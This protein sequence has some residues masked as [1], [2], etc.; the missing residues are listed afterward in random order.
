ME[1]TIEDCTKI[2][3]AKKKCMERETSGTDTDCNLHNCDDCSLCYEQGPMGEQKGALKFAVDTMHKYRKI[4]EIYNKWNDVN[5]F[6][7]KNAMEKIGEVLNEN[8]N[9]LY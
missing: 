2:L 4:Q 6:S 9:L 7:Y 5:D 1:M 3:I 8:N